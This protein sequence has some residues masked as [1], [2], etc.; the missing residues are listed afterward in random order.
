VGGRTCPGLVLINLWSGIPP[1]PGGFCGERW[2]LPKGTLSNSGR[3]T[4]NLE[5]TTT[6]KG[7]EREKEEEGGKI[8]PRG[9]QKPHKIERRDNPLQ[10]KKKDQTDSNGL[11]GG[12]LTKTV[13]FVKTQGKKTRKKGG[14]WETM[15]GGTN[16]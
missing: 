1:T 7:R 4:K 8:F 11:R 12:G 5:N 16:Y 13:I 3:V 14:Q 2:S 10:K 6:K 15:C 9:R